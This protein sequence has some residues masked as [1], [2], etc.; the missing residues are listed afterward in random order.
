MTQRAEETAPLPL[1]SHRKTRRRIQTTEFTPPDPGV[2]YVY[3]TI[4]AR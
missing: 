1:D 2:Y 4:E 3:L